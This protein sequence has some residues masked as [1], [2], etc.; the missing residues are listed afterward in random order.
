MLT[1]LFPLYL[2]FSSIINHSVTTIATAAIITTG[3]NSLE[4][5][6]FCALEFITIM[7]ITISQLLIA[8]S[9]HIQR[10]KLNTPHFASGPT[11][12]LFRHNPWASHCLQ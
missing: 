4:Q 6:N 7:I 9:P 8:H 5:V 11:C 2:H 1:S 3:E 10:G 12:T